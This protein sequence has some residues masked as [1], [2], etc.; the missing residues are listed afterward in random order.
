MN[1]RV[2]LLI[3][4]HRRVLV[5]GHLP[6][7]AFVNARGLVHECECARTTGSR[8]VEGG[9]P[10]RYFGEVLEAHSDR[11][12]PYASDSATSVAEARYYMQHE[13]RWELLRQRPDGI[14]LGDLAERIGV[15]KPF[16]T[17]AEAK[18]KMSEFC[19][20]LNNRESRISPLD[21]CRPA[22]FKTDEHAKPSLRISWRNPVA[23]TV[24][25]CQDVIAAT[26]VGKGCADFFLPQDSLILRTT[27]NGEFI[28]QL[29][30][31]AVG[32]GHTI[33]RRRCNSLFLTECRS[34]NTTSVS[35]LHR[36]RDPNKHDAWERFVI[37]YTPLLQYW[38]ARMGLQESDRSDLIQDVFAT[39]VQKLPEFRYNPDRSFRGWLRTL[40][41]NRW[42]NRVRQRVPTTLVAEHPALA[43]LAAPEVDLFSETE[44]RQQIV[45]RAL[46][47][48]QIDFPE[49]LWK[50]CWEHVVV[51]RAAA[52]VAT[53]LGI[54]VGTVYVAK[55]RIMSRLREELQGL[56][57]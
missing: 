35:L 5:F 49:R 10:R 36:L 51:G 28:E 41:L 1:L 54:A 4:I 48:M 55:A 12:S 13:P 46:Q 20:L 56:L 25:I 31:S 38:A 34:M 52:E 42:R 43:N 23:K 44:Y 2:M 19:D 18:A 6:R 17:I 9:L 32:I 53:E 21:Q 37:L 30:E 47:L 33:A 15:L 14:P 40:V 3:H 24:G 57:D 7:C 50:A 16:I 45:T 26:T 39:L 27:P 22:V 8:Y 11:G 29:H